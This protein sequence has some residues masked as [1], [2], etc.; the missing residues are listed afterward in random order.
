[1]GA[2]SPADDVVES[3]GS[4]RFRLPDWRP[5]RGAEALAVAALVIG[6]AA[7]YAAGHSQANGRAARPQPT[8]TVT[9][10]TPAPAASLSFT[11]SPALVQ[12]TSAC[13]VQ[14]GHELQLGI[15][16]TN[17]S[18]QPVTLKT[19]NAVLPMGGLK[20]VTYQWGTCGALADGLGQGGELVMLMPGDSAWL[21][22]T[23]KVQLNC[24]TPLPVEFK[25]GYQ[26]QGQPVTA[27][28]PGFP[29]LGQV[30]Y[31]GCSSPAQGN[32]SIAGVRR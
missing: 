14:A 15:Q 25:I 11:G 22:A 32:V 12:D 8:P 9:A 10:S 1:M 5:S 23:F 16:F 19:A 18:T 13:S 2:E 26:I 30:P 27:S 29:D 20:Q 17:Q 7:G 21:A 28:L 24:P 6:L 4:R 31:S 3:G